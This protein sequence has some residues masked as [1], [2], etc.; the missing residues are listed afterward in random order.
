VAT[1]GW[2]LVGLLRLALYALQQEFWN[3]LRVLKEMYVMEAS[4]EVWRYC[5]T[6]QVYIYHFRKVDSAL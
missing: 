4:G 2:L 6:L 5:K 3:A 1:V